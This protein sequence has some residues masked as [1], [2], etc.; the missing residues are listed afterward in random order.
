MITEFVRLLITLATTAAG[1]QIAAGPWSIPGLEPELTTVWGAVLGAGIGYVLG[2]VAGRRVERFV[3][4]APG[5]FE[6]MTG[7]QVIAGGAG[8]AVGTVLGAA[9]GAPLVALLPPPV[10]WP[11]AI[12]VV[13]VLAST[14]GGV[15]AS[16]A[17]EF[18]ATTTRS[19][20]G[21]GE[22][23]RAY[24]IDSSAAIDGRVLELSRSGL[25][26]GALWAPAFVVDELQTIADSA[27][28]E[29][30]RRG[31]R[32]LDVLEALRTEREDLVVIEDSVPERD[33]VD[34][35]LLVLA[36]RYGAMLVTTDHNLSRAAGLRGITTINPHSLGEALRPMLATGEHIELLI[37]KPGSEPGQGVGYLEDGTMVVVSEAADSI[38]EMLEVEISN[39]VRTSVGRMFFARPAP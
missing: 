1:F 10:G 16:K 22:G 23:D 29:R 21:R 15:F 8:L 38:G 11:L 36:E 37:S 17:T 27:D 19:V 6:N 5:W 30:R 26:P 13:V 20:G 25:L 18:G 4:G 31:R 12:L 32:G 9:L 3:D 33:E 7:P 14:A 35:K 28:R 34:A 39:M 24:L 2:G